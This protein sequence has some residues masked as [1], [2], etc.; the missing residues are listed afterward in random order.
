[1]GPCE[2]EE[3][4]ARVK[5]PSHPWY[6][7]QLWRVDTY[8]ALNALIQ[9]SA[10]R[11]TKLWM[12][13]VWREGV[14]PLLQMH[15]SLDCSVRSPEQAEIVARLCCEVIELDVPMR[16]DLKYGRNW[17]DATHTWDEVKNGAATH[18]AQKSSIVIKGAAVE[19]GVETRD[20]SAILDLIDW[21]PAES[22]DAAALSGEF[23]YVRS[24]SRVCTQCRL[25][26]GMDAHDD[27]HGGWLHPPCLN[28]F[29]NQCL[30]RE[31]YPHISWTAPSSPPPPNAPQRDRA[32]A[33]TS[34]RAST[35]SAT[36]GRQWISPTG[37]LTARS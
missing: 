33:T 12:R 5:D 2:I 15:D 24:D 35:G 31:S 20:A 6:G 23:A 10:A 17:G 14:V 1:L 29:I 21:Q 9:G 16:C 11:H 26:V 25:P 22:T 27:Q 28:A 3:A 13:A 30:V 4:R 32:T 36:W 19:S 7:K 18:T 37:W 8:T 34:D